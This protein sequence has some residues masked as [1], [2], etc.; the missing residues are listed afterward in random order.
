[1]K[2]ELDIKPEYKA[3][4]RQL[5]A[6]LPKVI[7]RHDI[8]ADARE[9]SAQLAALAAEN[10]VY[11]EL[12]CEVA[13][14]QQRQEIANAI[15]EAQTQ[16][17]IEARIVGTTAGEEVVGVG[18]DKRAAAQVAE[19]H[20]AYLPVSFRCDD[21]AD[22]PLA[23]AHG[24]DRISGA[25]TLYEDFSVNLEGISAG[26]ASAYLRD[27]E[28]PLEMSLSADLD[29]G[30]ID[31][32]GDHPL[33]LLQQLGFTCTLNPQG[34]NITDEMMLLVEG[35][36]YGLEELFELT[37]NAIEGAFAPIELRRSLLNDVIAPAYQ[38]FADMTEP[39][40]A[41]DFLDD[42]EDDEEDEAADSGLRITGLE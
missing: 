9:V 34:H 23:I 25:L 16:H 31:D 26:P 29:A 39:G 13:T 24:A 37:V 11:V 20:T 19:A 15:Q 38:Q 2:Q 18:V 14:E 3:L 12:R 7:L 27:R 42:E 22:F 21:P 4:D 35:F 8:E 1:M 36:D 5:V 10:V 30:L 33:P 41:T 32:I 17:G 40:V 28:V 6:Q